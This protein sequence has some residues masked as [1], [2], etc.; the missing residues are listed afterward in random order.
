MW[1]TTSV[2]L[3]YCYADGGRD[4]GEGEACNTYYYLLLT[5]CYLLLTTCYLLLTTCYLLLTTHHS[6]LTLSLTTL[7]T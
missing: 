3:C 1:W 2:L 4:L 5:T 6:L 7:S